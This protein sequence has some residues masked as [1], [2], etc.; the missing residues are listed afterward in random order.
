MTTRVRPQ[1]RDTYE[2]ILDEIRAGTLIPGERLTE[3]NIA[4]RFG[5]RN[6]F[7]LSAVRSI[8]KTQ[9]IL[10]PSTF[11]ESDRH[12]QSNKEH[13]K[14]LDTIK[15]RDPVNAEQAMRTHIESA[16]RVRL[17]QLRQHDAQ[18]DGPTG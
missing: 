17:R 8:E 7:L 14:L 2:R 6:R 5:A 13:E 18:P 9:L 12:A 1:G 15:S 10:G 16:H 4:E 11:H 3:S